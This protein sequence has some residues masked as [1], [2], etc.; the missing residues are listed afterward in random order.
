MRRVVAPRQGEARLAEG[1]S[2][3][4]GQSEA[5]ENHSGCEKGASHGR[6]L[7]PDR[8]AGKRWTASRRA[9]NSGIAPGGRPL[10]IWRIPNKLS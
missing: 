9:R 6:F 10:Y 1:R 5:K 3:P 8:A 2:R 4:G 7:H